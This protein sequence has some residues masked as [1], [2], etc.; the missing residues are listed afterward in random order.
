MGDRI[1]SVD[2][3]P[4]ANWDD[5]PPIIR[6]SPGRPVAFVVERDGA[7]LN[8]TATPATLEAD[9]TRAAEVTR[10]PAKEGSLVAG[11]GGTFARITNGVPE[12]FDVKP[13]TDRAELAAL[14][15]LRDAMGDLLALETATV[16]DAAAAPARSSPRIRSGWSA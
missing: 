2:G 9:A 6:A 4:I 1:V 12:R 7:R 16:D 5:V 14:L 11:R 15:G 13:K 8:L 10:G 3:R